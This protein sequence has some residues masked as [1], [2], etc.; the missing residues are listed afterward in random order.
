MLFQGVSNDAERVPA[1]L[2]RGEAGLHSVC[3]VKRI[4]QLHTSVESF[5]SVRS[6]VDFGLLGELNRTQGGC[7]LTSHSEWALQEESVSL[8]TILSGAECLGVPRA[9]L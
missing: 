5:F 9:A 7:T 6:P 8:S 2:E 4:P 3:S 1:L